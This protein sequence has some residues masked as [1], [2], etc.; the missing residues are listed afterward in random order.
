MPFNNKF[1]KD[2]IHVMQKKARKTSKPNLN[3][4][5]FFVIVIIRSM[6]I[7][8]MIVYAILFLNI[9]NYNI[10]KLIF[11]ILVIVSVK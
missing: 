2:C 7:R 3:L 4:S 11:K 9:R 10:K 5:Y 6:N 8:F 1:T